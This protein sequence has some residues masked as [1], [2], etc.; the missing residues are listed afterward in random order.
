MDDFMNR[1]SR[2][3]DYEALRERDARAKHDK[4]YSDP[5]TRKFNEQ[6]AGPKPSPELTLSR[7]HADERGEQQKRHHSENQRLLQKH[8]SDRG[9]RLQ[10]SNPLPANFDDKAERERS[11]LAAEHR[12]QREKM[13]RKHMAERDRL[14]SVR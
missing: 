9:R 4:L 8:Q 10:T 12:D 7:R 6:M 5:S 2:H 11:E 13:N 14:R 1:R 3:D